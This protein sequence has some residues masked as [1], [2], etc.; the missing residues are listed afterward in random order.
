MEG[1]LAARDCE[2]CLPTL[3]GR[4]GNDLENGCSGN[5]EEVDFREMVFVLWPLGFEIVTGAP[6]I[7]RNNERD[8]ERPGATVTC[9]TMDL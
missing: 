2:T 4:A 9:R 6:R 5:L 1:G 8:S 7:P 3:G